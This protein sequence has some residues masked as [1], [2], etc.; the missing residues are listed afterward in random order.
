MSPL[1]VV[2]ASRVTKHSRIRKMP[3]HLREI[4]GIYQVQVYVPPPLREIVAQITGHKLTP[5]DIK[6][7]R[8][9]PSQ[10]WLIKS[11]GTGNLP[12]AERIRDNTI[13]PKLL[14][15]LET[16]KAWADPGRLAD[17]LIRREPHTLNP[18]QSTVAQASA[19]GGMK[20]GG[21]EAG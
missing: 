20:Y 6:A 11:T 13:K 4:R 19:L 7:G 17:R 3:H 8:T 15:I 16:A 10:D 18:S 9:I 5:K 21:T 12:E 14:E 1:A 2:P